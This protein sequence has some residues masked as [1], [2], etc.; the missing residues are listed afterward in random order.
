M[1]EWPVRGFAF[2]LDLF[3]AMSL[4]GNKADISTAFCDV[5]F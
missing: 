2:L 3:D 1:A 5:H 4:I